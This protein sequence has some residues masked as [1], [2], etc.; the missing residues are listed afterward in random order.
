MINSSSQSGFSLIE[1]LVAITILMLV[2]VAPMT[3]TSQTAKSS[4]FASEQVTAFFLAQEGVE[5]VQKARDDL[6]VRHFLPDSDASYLAAPWD[7]FTNNSS[8]PMAGCFFNSACGIEIEDHQ[9]NSLN[10]IITPISCSTSNIEN[11]RLYRTTN[12]Q[13]SKFTHT[14]SGAEVT[15]YT[16][17]IS[18]EQIGTNEV[19]IVSRVTWRTGSLKNDQAVEVQ[20]RV[21]NIYGN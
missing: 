20:G 2:I 14:A 15:P 10:D 5:L 3:I 4:S 6:Q 16:R 13:R 12:N 19:K 17:T 9:T 1:T 21:F 18:L 8:G 7:S 11:C